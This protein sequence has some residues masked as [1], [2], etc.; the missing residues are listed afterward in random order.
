MRIDMKKFKKKVALFSPK[1]IALSALC[2]AGVSVATYLLNGSES[3][4]TIIFG[5]ICA[6]LIFLSVFSALPL[7]CSYSYNRFYV[8]ISYLFIKYRKIYYDEY[9]FV[10]VSNASYNNGLG[11][12]IYMNI[13]MQYKSKGKH[14]ST[15]TTYPFLMLLKS[16]YP[17]EKVRSKMYSRDLLLMDKPDVYCLGICWP[18][19][20]DELMKHTEMPVYI[21]E[22]VYLRFKGLFDTTFAAYLK[23][24]R[25]LFIVTDQIVPYE[26]Y[27]AN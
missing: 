23:G 9:D 18:G 6:A 12:G 10:F 14:K 7:G 20:L 1:K 25:Q 17:I 15:K 24:N 22:D 5:G 8:R 4:W 13:P 3:K 27:L 2:C 11:Y 21:L 16:T 26:K 19:S